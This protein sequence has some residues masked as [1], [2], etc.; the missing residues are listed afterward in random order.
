M[1]EWNEGHGLTVVWRLNGYTRIM[2]LGDAKATSVV[3]AL[4]IYL[5]EIGAPVRV[6]V[7]DSGPQFVLPP[8]LRGLCLLRGIKHI[9]LPLYAPFR[10]DSMR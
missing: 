2:L 10:E 3:K 8:L 9:T 7:S 6:L 5:W 4:E 1:E